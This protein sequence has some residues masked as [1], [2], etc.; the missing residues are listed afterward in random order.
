MTLLNELVK[1]NAN[2]GTEGRRYGMVT[3]GP[4]HSHF[5]PKI[6]ALNTYWTGVQTATGSFA[7]GW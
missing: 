5:T 6:S 3:A 2:S 4:H 1:C 7:I